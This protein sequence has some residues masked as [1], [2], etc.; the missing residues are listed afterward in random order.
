[1]NNVE[2]LRDKSNKASRIKQTMETNGWEDIMQIFL[3]VYNRSMNDLLEKEND[4]ARGAIN[5]ITEIMNDISSDLAFGE[6][7]RKKYTE[8]YV[9]VKHPDGE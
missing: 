8:T 7:A 6:K 2:A 4:A 1:M 9:N 5:A 3:D